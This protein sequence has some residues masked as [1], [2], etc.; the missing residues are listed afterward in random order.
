MERIDELRKRIDEIDKKVAQLFEERMGISSDIL[1]Y[2]LDHALPIEDLER[3]KAMIIKES[4]YIKDEVIKEY[5]IEFLNNLITLSKNYQKN[6]D[7]TPLSIDGS[8]ALKLKINVSNPYE[9][10]ID[11]GSLASFSNYIDINR[12]ILIITDSNIPMEYINTLKKCLNQDFLYVIKAG[13]ASKSI[14]EY[15]NIME[16]L[17]DH[18][19]NRRD[20]II[21][22]GGG[23]VGDLSA[24]IASTYMRG[25]DFYNIPTS[26][27]A[28]VDSSIGGKCAIDF[29]DI[30]NILGSFYQPK[31]VLIDPDLLK[32]LDIRELHSGL[33][34]SIKMAMSFNE[35]LFSLIE[36][37]SDLMG[38][39]DKI[40][41]ESLKI[42][43]RIVEL[44]TYEKNLRSV[45]NFG[46]TIGHA[47]ELSNTNLLH[48]EAVGIGMT[49]FSYNEAKER[50]IKVLNKYDLPIKVNYEKEKILSLI[51]HDKKTIK[52]KV[53]IIKCNKIGSYKMDEMSLDEIGELLWIMS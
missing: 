47:L 46:H 30:K 50:L 45:L 14:E 48:G 23:V 3:E 16:Y 38:D 25:I 34:E 29:N 4:S 32:T 6:L 2:K 41:Y 49:Y 27:L 19:F 24:F 43:A 37:S 7:S 22:L 21:A 51:S 20:A 15:K 18:N 5:Y 40:I 17:I 10:V 39:I 28:M 31:F 8:N 12:K 52:D 44:D 35:K 1:K 26:L 36:N 13:E 42:K 11:R 33:V 53:K 9:I